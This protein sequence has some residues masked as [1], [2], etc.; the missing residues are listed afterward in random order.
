MNRAVFHGKRR[1]K[2]LDTG[3]A[4][5][6][7]RGVIL[8]KPA[9][10]TGFMKHLVLSSAV[11][12]AFI[13]ALPARAQTT[14]AYDNANTYPSQPN[15]DWPSVNGGSGYDLWT[16]VSD[17]SG[18]GTYMEGIDANNRQVDGNFS[19]ALYSGSGGYDISRA[20]A[21]PI[22]SGTFSILTRFDTSG[23][24]LDLVNLRSGNSTSAFG[25]GELL[26]FGL[27]NNNQLSYTD[28]SGFHTLSSGEARGDVWDW[29]VTFNA[30]AGTYSLSVAEVGGGYSTTVNGDLESGGNSVG[31][32][33]VINTS[34]GSGQN[35]IFDTPE[36]QVPEP[37]S[38][39]LL[40]TGVLGSF[41]LL[42]R[43]K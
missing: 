41:A 40:A 18:G 30:T 36:L 1:V 8:V 25:G 35:V 14:V 33:A 24:G 38:L 19:F 4:F 34:T 42:R 37:S 15:N 20:L 21:T 27:V 9:G 3:I 11:A 16:P 5:C 31:S 28:S 39:A 29:T 23:S 26:S 10:N 17:T 2:Q 32:F 6:H 7:F 12:T 13:V 43:R 22:T